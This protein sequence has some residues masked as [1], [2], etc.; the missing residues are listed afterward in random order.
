MKLTTLNTIYCFCLFLFA[1]AAP[2]VY[3]YE[4]FDDFEDGSHT[5]GSPTTWLGSGAVVRDGRLTLSGEFSQIQPTNDSST[6]W[7][8]KASVSHT[9][10]SD[11]PGFIV[12]NN[13]AA[14]LNGSGFLEIL[15]LSSWL[16][17]GPLRSEKID[18]SPLEI[19]SYLQLD[20]FDG[21]LRA[22]AW[23]VGTERPED[24]L[25]GSYDARF[26][27]FPQLWT[28]SRG[29]FLDAQVSSTRSIPEPSNLAMLMSLPLCL[30]GRRSKRSARL[31]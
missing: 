31:D 30:L 5:D 25:I 16:S 1:I 24:P 13:Y 7:S 19:D 6:S 22:W 15:E 18:Y 8:I 11:I 3:G 14:Y 12:N 23:P 9:N 26:A 27:G 10:T 17:D 28:L 2:P 29:V 21:E 4:L 20:A